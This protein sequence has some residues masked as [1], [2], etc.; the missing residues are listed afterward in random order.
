M[1]GP[2]VGSTSNSGAPSGTC[3]PTVASRAVTVRVTSW[4]SRRMVRK[5]SRRRAGSGRLR[6]WREELGE[7]LS[8][9]LGMGQRGGVPDAR[10]LVYPC[11]GDVVGHVP[12]AGGQE[13]L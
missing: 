2:Y 10:D 3:R 12:R 9:R 11:V 13:R 7:C 6:R 8:E 5:G 4:P 1:P